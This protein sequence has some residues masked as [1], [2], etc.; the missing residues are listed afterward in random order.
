MNNDLKEVLN[1]RDLVERYKT[2]GDNIAFKY[3]KDNE[4]K[5]ITYNKYVEDV[6]ALGTKLLN[7]GITKIAVIGMNSYKWCTT[8]MATLTSGLI[9]VPLDKMLTP[10][11]II[12]LVQRSG[13]EAIIFEEKTLEAIKQCDLKY[14]ICMD[15]IEEDGIIKY[16]EFLNQ[17]YDLLKEDKKYSEVKINNE[18]M[19]V[20]LFTSGTTN[21]PKAV[22]LSHSNL[23]SQINGL[24]KQVK[25]YQ[26][27]TLLS[28][29]PIHHTFECAITFLFG[30]SSGATIAFCE[31][32]KYIAPNLK[33]F[34]V[35]VFV[36]V[37]LVLETMYKKIQKGIEERGKTKVVN[38]LIKVSNFLLK[39]KIDV[40]RKLFKS[41]LDNLSP[42]LRV[43]LYGAAPM[44]KD[45]VIGYT[46][47]GLESIQGYGL[48]ESSP[49]I[50]CERDDK[51]RPGS[52]GIPLPGVEVKIDK[53]DAEG[54]GEVMAK[55][56]NIMMGYYNNEEATKKTLEDGWLHTGDYGYIDSDGFVFITGRKSDVIVLSSGKN[57]Y[58]Q[59]IEFLI[60]KLTYVQ[61]SLIYNVKKDAIEAKIV[62][63]KELA[64]EKFG[65][66][67][68]YK[69]VILTEIKEINKELPTFKR[70]NKI[71]VTDEPLE[72]TTTQ[73]VKRFVEIKKMEEVKK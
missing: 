51:K 30:T 9:I 44:D 36:A 32:L 33:E 7:C 70:I 73:K 47:I 37:P 39:C 54:I 55:G 56:Q 8:Y 35:S 64:E 65:K 57:I 71:V 40:R 41:I 2:F 60:N 18:E 21:E 13:A 52:V 15:D 38:K 1:L 17:G 46:N 59:E 58:P 69:E 31:G 27:D 61:E 11:E 62:I 3:K 42:S 26:T 4:I 20:M 45:T 49:V 12:K 19:S 24:P 66:Q 29:L 48:T 67:E 22:M 28:F 43:V 68:D 6:E 34:N 16:S 50:A 5:E 63:N 14:K 23:A 72:K 25:L 53:P 10:K